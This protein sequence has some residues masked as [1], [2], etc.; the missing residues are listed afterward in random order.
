[1][2]GQWRFGPN[3]PALALEAL[4]QRR[5]LAAYVRACS[6]AQFDVAVSEQ[7]ARPREFERLLEHPDRARVLRSNVD[8]ALACTD[9]EAADRHAL[10]QGERVA[11][12][13]HAI[14]ESSGVTLVRVADDVAN[15]RLRLAYGAPLDP[16]REARATAPAQTGFDQRRKSRLG[17]E[18]A[19]LREP[20]SAAMS[21]EVLPGQWIDDAA[22]LEGPTCLARHERV[23]LG[24]ADA[25]RMGGALKP[26]GLK[27][28]H[29]IGET[30]GSIT[31]APRGGLDLHQRLEPMHTTGPRAHDLH[32]QLASGSLVGDRHCDCVSAKR[33]RRGIGRNK[34]AMGAAHAISVH[35]YRVLQRAVANQHERPTRHPQVPQAL[36]NT[37]PGR[38]QV[39]ASLAHPWSCHAT[40]YRVS[41]RLR[42]PVHRH[43]SPDTPRHGRA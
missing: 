29:H 9:H 4:V 28:T 36:P 42:S 41:R 38:T 3:L 11:L 43:P 25:Q 13:Q 22:T 21:D 30:H 37:D 34:N 27:Q 40:S 26:A 31:D 18:R 35:T 32:R 24:R 10:D 15:V 1:M 20:L 7:A 6:N 33:E 19:C 2:C 17:S 12:H 8:E 14:G 39:R 23:R 16:R 5:F